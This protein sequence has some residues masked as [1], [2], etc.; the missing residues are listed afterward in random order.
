[1]EK[2]IFCVE[3]FSV[4]KKEKN[5]QFLRNFSFRLHVENK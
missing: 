1:M 4:Q 5:E 2:K 3:D